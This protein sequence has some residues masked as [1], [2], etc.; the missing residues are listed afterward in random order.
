MHMIISGH[1]GSEQHLTI[2]T[3]RIIS[4]AGGPNLR[5]HLPRSWLRLRLGLIGSRS[6]R[7]RGCLSIRS[8]AL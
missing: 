6:A 4:E 5:C 7:A 2:R 3:I 8:I 1:C